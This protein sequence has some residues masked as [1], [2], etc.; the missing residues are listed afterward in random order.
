MLGVK[1]LSGYRI[2]SRPPRRVPHTAPHTSPGQSIALAPDYA[3]CGPTCWRPVGFR[4][5]T[6]PACG[7]RENS[8]AGVY[9]YLV[10][11]TALV[12]EDHEGWGPMVGHMTSPGSSG[13]TPMKRPTQVATR[14]EALEPD[15]LDATDFQ[16]MVK[17]R[18]RVATR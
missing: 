16:M 12:R 5:S 13:V 14:A 1:A 18:R 11:S 4:T 7:P 3:L 17:H 6:A 8:R 9:L 10:R 2:E 15:F